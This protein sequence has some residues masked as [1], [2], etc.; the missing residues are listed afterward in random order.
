MAGRGGG[1][2][3]DPPPLAG[4][5][6]GD[7]GFFMDNHRKEPPNS[8]VSHGNNTYCSSDKGAALAGER[9]RGGGK[10]TQK[11]HTNVRKRRQVPKHILRHA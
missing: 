5:W 9:G 11:V 10:R 7:W 6:G 4:P 8:M 1:G 2:F 3:Q